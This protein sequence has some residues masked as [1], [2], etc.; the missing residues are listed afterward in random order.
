MQ[1]VEIVFEKYRK[2]N[3]VKNKSDLYVGQEP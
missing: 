2:W 1:S 3:G